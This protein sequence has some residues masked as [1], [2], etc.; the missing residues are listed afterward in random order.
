MC[1]D[2]AGRVLNIY[3]H[4]PH[5]TETFVIVSYRFQIDYTFVGYRP[6]NESVVANIK[7]RRVPIHLR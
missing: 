1:D 5:A 6:A 3:S 4:L 7:S 2:D